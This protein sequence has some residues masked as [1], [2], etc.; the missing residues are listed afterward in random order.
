MKF[1]WDEAKAHENERKHSVP[2]L[3]ATSC[4]ADESALVL[5]DEAHSTGKELRWFLI[6]RSDAGRVLTVRY[7]HRGQAIRLIGAGA[8]REGKK[9]YDK[10]NRARE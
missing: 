1:E 3:E 2:F 9:L 4:F 8:W 7:T 10:L 6:G 5:L